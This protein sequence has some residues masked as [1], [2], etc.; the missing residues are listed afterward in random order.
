MN[1]ILKTENLS[2]DYLIN[3]RKFNVLKNIDIK[4]KAGDFVSVMGPSGSGKSTLL[5]NVS[6]MDKM[7][8]GEV[9][10]QGEKLSKLNEKKLSKLRLKNYL[11]GQCEFLKNI[12]SSFTCRM[13]RLLTNLFQ[14]SFL[15]IFLLFIF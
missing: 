15:T 7:S 14:S 11:I 6:G 10:F 13:L 12:Y 8:S 4:I 5:Y 2:K 1:E 3:K 9:I